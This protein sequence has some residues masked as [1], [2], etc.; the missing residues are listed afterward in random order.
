[1]RAK[2]IARLR[3]KIVLLSDP[4]V[5]P[6][7]SNPQFRHYFAIVRTRVI[8][9]HKLCISPEHQASV[10]ADILLSES[11]LAI[12]LH[13]SGMHWDYFADRD[14]LGI[15]VPGLKLDLKPLTMF[16]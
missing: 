13:R 9:S 6:Q 14:S 3:G 15:V 10:V 5:P 12:I 1:M 11:S 16:I 7:H 8:L 2:W 4:K